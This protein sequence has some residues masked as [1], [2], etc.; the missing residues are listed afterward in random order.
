[1]NPW[2]VLGI[3]VV[4]SALPALAFVLRQWRHEQEGP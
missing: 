4:L 2:M 3:C 1:M